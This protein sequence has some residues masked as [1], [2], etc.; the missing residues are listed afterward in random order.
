MAAAGA[1]PDPAVAFRIPVRRGAPRAYA[2]PGLTAL[3]AGF[4]PGPAVERLLGFSRDDDLVYVLERGRLAALDL[5]IGRYRQLDSG[6]VQAAMGPTGAVRLVVGDTL[7]A[8]AA[9]RR[10]TPIGPRPPGIIEALWQGP[11]DRTLMVVATDSGRALVIL[12]GDVVSSRRP[13]PEGPVTAARWGD[14]VAV[15]TPE[16]ITIFE[17]LRDVDPVSVRL[18][19]DVTAI[20]FSGSGHR[21]YVATAAPALLVLERYEGDEVTRLALPRPVTALRAGAFGRYLFMRSGETLLVLDESDD[22]LHRLAG[23]WD[24][25]LPASAPDGTVLIR[26]DDDVLA[27]QPG[28]SVPRGTVADGAGDRWVVAL[29]SPDGRPERLAEA[30]TASSGA[31]AGGVIYLQV[32]S[33]SNPQWAEGL[34]SDLRLAGMR[35]TV[36][37]PG[38]ADE[39]YRVVLGPY[40]TR[41]AAEEIGRRLGMPYWI[42]QRDTT[43]AAPG[44][45]P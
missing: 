14:A 7:L 15:A 23:G 13:L 37:P 43:G 30:G 4:E 8:T 17:T 16:G 2:L 19:D 21:L 11:R 39:M 12:S 9:E 10:V 29:W 33:T 34:A 31:G 20:A 22:G 5:R 44:A 38:T 24:T 6:V 1:A 25:D 27:V 26:Q 42:F 41:E 18:Q 40:P 35:A 3:D 32:S 28:D 36:L 45:T